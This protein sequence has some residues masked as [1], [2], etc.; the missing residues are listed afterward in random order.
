MKKASFCFRNFRMVLEIGQR[1]E[2]DI[3]LFHIPVELG[4]KGWKVRLFKY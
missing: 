1:V 4:S 2:L 3:C